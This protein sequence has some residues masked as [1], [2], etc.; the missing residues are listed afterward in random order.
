MLFIHILIKIFLFLYISFSFDFADGIVN[1]NKVSHPL[2]KM[3][4]KSQPIVFKY[5][6][7]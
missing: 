5:V 3:A 6:A 7:A 4:N 2:I 1:V